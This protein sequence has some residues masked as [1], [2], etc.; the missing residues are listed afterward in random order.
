MNQLRI[1]GHACK[2]ATS[3]EVLIGSWFLADTRGDVI[4]SYVGDLKV[5]I[6]SMQMKAT[7][8]IVAP[9]VVT[10]DERSPVYKACK[11][12]ASI[13][14]EKCLYGPEYTVY[15]LNGR[16]IDSDYAT[17][18]LGNK[19]VRGLASMIRVGGKYRLTAQKRVH[20]K[21]TWYVPNPIPMGED[22]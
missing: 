18:F 16:T 4:T 22:E 19:S 14:G 7:D 20:G 2:A 3:G 9:P 6:K 1:A 13:K 15:V 12:R 11:L 10:F 21:F 5:S 17:L 8:W